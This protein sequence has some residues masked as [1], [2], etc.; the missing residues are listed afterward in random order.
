MHPIYLF[1]QAILFLSFPESLIIYCS[2]WLTDLLTSYQKSELLSISF[3]KLPSLMALRHCLEQWAAWGQR[4]P[5]RQK[6]PPSSSGGRCWGGEFFRRG[7]W[8]WQRP[9]DWPSPCRWSSRGT[10]EPRPDWRRSC[11]PR[12]GC[13]SP[14]TT[15]GSAWC[16][17][18]QICIVR[19]RDNN[20]FTEA[21]SNVSTSLDGSIYPRWK[22]SCFANQKI[23]LTCQKH[24]RLYSGTSSAICSWRSFVNG[25]RSMRRQIF[26]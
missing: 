18:G 25:D 8:T 12:R 24:I 3:L 11:E 7:S 10:E 16:I 19:W 14:P 17:N 6:I 21:S 5:R 2:Y 15:A 13:T 20:I 1:P 4:K 23:L 26:K 22:M 9:Q